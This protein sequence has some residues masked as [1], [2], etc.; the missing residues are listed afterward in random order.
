MKKLLIL[1]VMLT[2]A[3]VVFA[4]VAED[5]YYAADQEAPQTTGNSGS[6]KEFDLEITAGIPFHWTDSHERPD[7]NKTVTSSL[8][9]GLGLTFNFNRKFGITLDTD[10]SFARSLY[11]DPTTNSNFYSLITANALLGPVI[12]LYNG[13]FLRIPLAF[14]IHYYFFS[15][16][17]WDATATGV[18][19]KYTDHQFGPG[20][21]LGIQFHFNRSLY[22][23]SRTNVNY[24]IGRFLVSKAGTGVGTSSSD[25]D[26][27]WVGALS[28]KPT[29]GLGIKF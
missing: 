9:L 25:S 20:A 11:G 26:F 14:G 29:I 17:H 28:V 10:I 19:W 27:E 16:D 21:Y 22:I 2:M 1:M 8:S 23:L 15:G 13:S 5:E 18:F 4:Q 24:D 6:G 7:E 12:Y 3:F